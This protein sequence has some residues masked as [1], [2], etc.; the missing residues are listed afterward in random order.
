MAYRSRERVARILAHRESDRVPFFS[1]RDRQVAELVAAMGLAG[2][3]REF[4][5][6]GDFRYVTFAARDRRAEFAAYLPGLPPE[7]AVSDWGVGTMPLTSA[8]GD[9]AGYRSYYPLA[10]VD[11][12]AALERFPFPDMTECWRHRDLEA[13]VRA[14]KDAGYTVVG[15]MSQTILEMAYSMR[16]IEQLMVDLY[17]RPE[18][19]AALFEKLA[20]RRCFQ[21]RRFAEAGV[22]VLRIGDDIATQTSLLVSPELYRERVKPFHARVVAAARAVRPGL[23]VLYHSDG[24]LRD[25]LPD[26]VEAGVTAIN[27]VQPECMDLAAVKREFGRNLVL[28]GCCSVQSVYATGSADDVRRELRF[29]MR[30]IAPG[31]GLVLQFT[32]MVLSPAVLANLRVFFAEFYDLGRY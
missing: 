24:N 2:E 17:E 29:L 15:Q 32:N 25:L 10:N 12:A 28:W 27:P 9:A 7:A 16:G 14:A 5:L 3:H 1:L 13:E 23:P 21:A 22:D 20:E 11:T 31:G 4:C 30:E 8:D 18:F 6:E 19:V 26:L